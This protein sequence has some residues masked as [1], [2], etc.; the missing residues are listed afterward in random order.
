EFFSIGEAKYQL[1]ECNF[2]L[3]NYNSA[4]ENYNSF[5]ESFPEGPRSRMAL[6]RIGNAYQESQK[7]QKAYDQYQKI[8]RQYP[9]TY[10][11]RISLDK[12]NELLSS[13]PD[14]SISRED[15]FYNGLVL[16]KAQRYESARKEFKKA[17]GGADDL[18]TKV[19]YFIAESY[20]DE[21]KYLSAKEEYESL[22]KRYPNNQYKVNVWFKIAMCSLKLNQSV[23]LLSDFA[24][25]FPDSELVDDAI[26]ELA[27]N[28]KEK[29]NYK[30]AIEIYNKIIDKYPS[31]DKADDAL[32][33]IGWCYINSRD[34]KNAGETFKKL[35]KEYKDSD[36]VGSSRFLA[37]FCYEKS[38]YIKEA[39]GYYLESIQNKDWYYADR[40]KRRIEFLVKSGKVDEKSASFQYKK[41]EINDSSQ[42]W[43]KIRE[44]TPTW[45]VELVNF[46]IYDD[47]IN[48]LK[49]LEEIDIF[50]EVT[51]YYLSLCYEKLGEYHRSWSYAW[52][53]G[54]MPGIK[55]EKDELPSQ[56]I[57]R[58]YPSAYKEHIFQYSKMNN[59]DPYLVSA[60][61]LEESKYNINAKSSSGAL[62]LMQII[63]STGKDIA[64]KINIKNFKDEM[65]Y[66]PE[67][68]IKMG[69]WYLRWLMDTFNEHLK[70]KNSGTNSENSDH[71]KVLILGA[72]NGGL[73]RIRNWIDEYGIDDIDLFVET[74]PL[75]EPKRY[76]KKVLD[77]YEA[78]KSLYGS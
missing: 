75:T 43:K 69:T 30:K 41:T 56:V 46:A 63:P 34:Y 23:D 57:Y 58:M 11:A 15:H 16:Y 40:S 61:I 7:P 35:A 76:I 39:L 37:G 8:I 62:G 45:I 36:F 21:G 38:G 77:S 25:D 73:T 54:Q 68:N 64:N 12:I 32:W 28:F 71:F 51:Y 67:T 1:A 53:L 33:N 42:S 50:P 60:V 3:K 72:Y 74:I 70:K 49:P 27:N 14:L 29:K 6:F 22:I 10:S 66:D 55:G 44:Q 20:Y 13:S 78:Y 47:I 52:R 4:I 17:I 5:L 26:L 65:L 59:V 31:G 18:N 48:H 2:K 9:E 19:L 24:E